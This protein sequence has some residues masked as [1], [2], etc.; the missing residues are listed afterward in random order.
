MPAGYL[1]IVDMYMCGPA[2]VI[3][4]SVVTPMQTDLV[5]PCYNGSSLV[6]LYALH[7]SLIVGLEYRGYSLEAWCSD[8]SA[9]MCEG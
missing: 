4:L 7:V 5:C 1:Y 8:A 9:F 2:V 3:S 6:I